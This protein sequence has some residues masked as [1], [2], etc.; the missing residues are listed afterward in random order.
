MTIPVGESEYTVILSDTAGQEEYDRLR[1]LA[2]P[3]VSS[4]VGNKTRSWVRVALHSKSRW[5]TYNI[6]H[7][8]IIFRARSPIESS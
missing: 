2:Y 4:D 1:P 6:I 3:E 5:L 7:Y 8:M